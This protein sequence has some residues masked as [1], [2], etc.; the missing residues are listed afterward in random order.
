VL[1]RTNCL[2]VDTVVSPKCHCEYAKLKLVGIKLHLPPIFERT[3]NAAHRISYDF[4]GSRGGG[5]N[6]AAE[7]GIARCRPAYVTNDS[8]GSLSIDL[9]RR[10]HQ[11]M[12]RPTQ[13][14]SRQTH[15]SLASCLRAR[16]MLHSF[17]P[18]LIHSF[19]T[20]ESSRAQSIAWFRDLQRNVFLWSPYG[21]GQTIIFLLCSFSFLLSFP[22]LIS[23]VGDWMP[24]ALPHMVWPMCKFR[25][26]VW[27]VLHAARWKYRT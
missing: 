1:K 6:A 14:P 19:S 3:A 27:N 25:M 12:H 4:M 15:A 8:D 26:Q 18:S 17:V 22:G 13:A 24:A 2:A 20:S 23:A 7:R 5:Y 11:S 10:R 16:R 9:S 21:I